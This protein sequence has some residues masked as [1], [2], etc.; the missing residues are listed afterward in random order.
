MSAREPPYSRAQRMALV[1]SC[2]TLWRASRWR[3]VLRSSSGREVESR[4]QER[5][6]SSEG[7]SMIRIASQDSRYMAV[8]SS[9][10]RVRSLRR[11]VPEESS[12]DASPRKAASFA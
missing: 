7:M 9:G 10:S 5:V 1:I 3:S 4:Y 12:G 11:N 6:M 8:S 2:L